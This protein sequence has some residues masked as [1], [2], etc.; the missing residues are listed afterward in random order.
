MRAYHVDDD[1]S[2]VVSDTTG[3]RGNKIT[4]FGIVSPGVSLTFSLKPE[5]G[6]ALE[7]LI[8]KAVRK[9]ARAKNRG[10]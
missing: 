4:H 9:A 1:N 7:R 2:L 10:H 8:A 5:V 3:P 6:G